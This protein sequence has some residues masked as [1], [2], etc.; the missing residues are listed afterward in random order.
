[1]Q[2]FLDFG[3][4]AVRSRA[5]RLGL[6]AAFAMVLTG[7]STAAPAL[8]QEPGAIRGA[9][10]DPGTAQPVSGAQVSLRGTTRGTLTDA[11]GI[12]L[13][14]NV[15]PGQYTVRIESIG[16]RTVEQQVTV[17][18]GETAVTEM[19]MAASAIGLDEI[20]VTGTAGRTTRR[21]LGNSVSSV[22]AAAV[23]EVAPVANVQQLLQG[24]TAGL[25][26]LPSSGVVGGSSRMRV[27]GLGSL[28]GGNEPVVY[29][30]GVRMFSGTSTT[31]GNTAQGINRMDSINPN[32]IESIEVIKGPAA[33][34]LYG[35]DAA[36]G[37]IQI[38]TKRGRPAEGLQW[39]ANFEYG[40]IDW[41]VDQPV[42]YWLC[43]D[44]HI[45]A[46]NSFPGCAQFTVDQPLSERRLIDHPFDMSRRS[47][48]VYQQ[49]AARGLSTTDWECLFPQQEP[50]NPA[51]LRSG[52]LQSQ[53]MSVRGGGEAFN[54]FISGERNR[55]LGTFF[56]NHNHRTSARANFGFVPS[57]RAN[58]NVNVNYARQEQQIP[59]SDN[60]SNSILR[61]A[62]R[63]QA[64]GPNSQ[65]LPGYRNMHPE[66]SNK[67]DRQQFVERVLM[68]VT[69]NYDPT[70]WWQNRLTFG[71]DRHER[72]N[73]TFNQ[74]DQTGLSPFG[75]I[76]ATGRMQY[77][78]PTVY[79]WTVD[80]SGTA[81]ARISDDL[82][83]AFSAGMQYVKGRTDTY[84]LD[85]QG[86]VANKLNLI[87]SA[88][89]TFSGQSFSEQISLG[90]YLQEQLGWRDRLFGTFAVRIDDNSAFGSEFS[91]VVYPKASLSWVVSEEPFFRWNWIEEL[92]LR[93]AWGQAGN[94][95][96]PFSADRTYS[97][98]RA[99]VN[100][101][102]VNR[103]Q[104]SAYGNPNLKAETGQEIELGFDASFLGGRLTTDLTYFFQQTKD[105]LVSLNA[106]PSSGW[107]GSYLTNIGEI[108]NSGLELTLDAQLMQRQNV[109]WNSM[110]AMA[111]TANKLVSFGR[112]AEGN[113]S[114][115][116]TRFGPFIATQRHRE[117]YPLGGFWR[118]DVVRDAQGN[119]V[120]DAAGR[121]IVPSCTW[122]AQTPEDCSEEYAG[123][124]L[125]KL[126][127]GFTNRV[128]LFNNLTLYAFTDYQGGH[129]KFCA[130]C[131]VRTR[132]D[133]NTE[134]I[135]NPDLTAVE[136][137]RLL[138]LQTVDYVSKS[139]FLKLRE[140]SATYAIPSRY[141]QRLGF[142]R[143][144]VTAAGRNLWMWTNYIGGGDPEV[145][146]SSDSEFES[147][148]YAS[149]P[150]LRRLVLSVNLNF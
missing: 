48:A 16:F 45:R 67:H 80:Y 149:I 68:S 54:F 8:A 30:D 9:V 61:N 134:E 146:F 90:F 100:N 86:L 60:S 113:P 42:T 96:S 93:T 143:A 41:V 56:N 70:S 98:A 10:T 88:A 141:T 28:S 81:T 20:V 24:R 102:A 11:R 44:A 47:S 123:P 91:V 148:D 72:E 69:S 50:C 32:D 7:M 58:F 4:R 121:A 99:V 22:N 85:G 112:D 94:A 74:I 2:R 130:L 150:M 46:P 64:G 103:L 21:A 62:Y 40:T 38:I 109:R 18:A 126:T 1:M 115:D 83:S 118:Q 97:T 117:G 111:T 142:N 17:R 12:F 135:T 145:T 127:L 89:Q 57:P 139:D 82:S 55:E 119:V 29:I 110:L 101:E 76:A 31:E 66:F 87:S 73:R 78:I 138:S 120:L 133:L 71:M 52:S 35:A 6:I 34:T 5:P 92:K 104:T 140:V 36:A 108:Q 23:T 43:T 63:G 129:Y 114:R 49:L 3:S 65:Y 122:P 128:T 39:N 131:S 14:T 13:I 125:P 19:Q 27:R 15:A 37:V 107:T 51:P 53:N 77:S 144:A 136:R 116:E 105:A 84:S 132:L 25:T 26:V 59:Q 106:P 137:A 95:P 124:M 79:R 147:A 75:A 33:A